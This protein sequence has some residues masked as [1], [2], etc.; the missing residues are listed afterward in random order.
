V[1]LGARALERARRELANGVKEIPGSEHH[2]Q[3]VRYFAD[4][5]RA[6]R[7]IG[8]HL[9][10][11]EHAWCAAALC[12]CAFRAA[13]E[14]ETVPHGY[15]AAVREVWLDALASG[16][17]R[18][19]DAVRRGAYVPQDGDAWIG[20]RGGSSAH[21]SGAD[22]FRRTNGKGHTGRF[23]DASRFVTLDGNVADTWTM[24]ERDPNDP[25]FV[26]VVSY[27]RP[28][29]SAVIPSDEELDG[30]RRLWELHDDLRDGTDTALHAELFDV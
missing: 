24:V 2:P 12:W 8:R 13:R 19:A 28:D 26:G 9:D 27:P 17:A 5:M 16:A 20:V 3:I 15:R 4:C 14:G 6:G 21:G 22:A 29:W 1:P 25:A 30:A 23:S 10:A 11:D 7:N 18:S